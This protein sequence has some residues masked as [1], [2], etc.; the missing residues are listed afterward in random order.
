[1]RGVE[2]VLPD[3]PVDVFFRAFGDWARQVQVQWWIDDVNLQDRVLD[4]VNWAIER[5]LDEAGI[6]MPFQTYDLNLKKTD[7]QE[8]I[9]D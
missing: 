1:V 2:G 5:A 9:A 4:R 7:D 3:K 6:E 8:S